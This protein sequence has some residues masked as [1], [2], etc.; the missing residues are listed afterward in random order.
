[1]ILDIY[2]FKKREDMYFVMIFIVWLSLVLD[3]VKGGVNLII[4]LFLVVSM[5]RF[6]CRVVLISGVVGIFNLMLISR[7]ILWIFFMW[8]FVLIFF[9]SWVWRW[10]F[11]VVICFKKFGVC[12]V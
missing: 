11:L 1:M 12:K 2:K 3:M 4:Y 6:V 5:R 10:L 9:F 7:F 8:G